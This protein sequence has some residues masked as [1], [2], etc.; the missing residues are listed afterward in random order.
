MYNLINKLYL[1]NK[2][3][4]VVGSSEC[5][6]QRPIENMHLINTSLKLLPDS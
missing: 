1:I 6:L 3:R 5:R 4:V 2:L